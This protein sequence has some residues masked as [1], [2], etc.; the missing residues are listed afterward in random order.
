MN[1]QQFLLLF[2]NVCLGTNEQPL[3]LLLF[4]NLWIDTTIKCNI[5]VVFLLF[6]FRN[7][8]T[9]IWTFEQV[10]PQTPWL[11]YLNKSSP[12]RSWLEHLNRLGPQRL[13]HIWTSWAPRDPDLN[14]WT[15]WPP[16]RPWLNYLNKS[17]PQGTPGHLGIQN[18]PKDFVGVTQAT[19]SIPP[20]LAQTFKL[21]CSEHQQHS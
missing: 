5:F 3:F 11:D 16:Q 18:I 12:Q 10:S 13:W 1:K 17:G 19:P 14:I 4:C 8:E 6:V 21:H 2:C 15:S 9:M 7:P 20:T